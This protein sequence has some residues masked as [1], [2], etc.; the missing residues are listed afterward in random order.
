MG[1]AAA[2]H[3]LA[4]TWLGRI[5]MLIWLWPVLVVLTLQGQEPHATGIRWL[6]IVIDLIACTIV[7]WFVAS[8]PAYLSGYRRRRRT[9]PSSTVPGLEIVAAAPESLRL[10]R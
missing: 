4:G 9:A 8:L 10:S 2:S 1:W 3:Y 6:L 7:A 5:A